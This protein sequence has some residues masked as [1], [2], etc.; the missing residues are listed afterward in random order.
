VPAAEPGRVPRVRA[1]TAADARAIGEVQ[2]L[3]WRV[4]YRGIVDDAFIDS[5]TIEAREASWRERLDDIGGMVILVLESADGAVVGF[6]SGGPCR[7]PDVAA[8]AEL[9]AIYILPEHQRDR[10]GR[11]LVRAFAREMSGRGC[12]TMLVQVLAENPARR[13]YES[14]GAR[15]LDDRPHQMGD[16]VYAEARYLWDDFATLLEA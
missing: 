9:Y 13:F 10:G 8:D 12:R 14:L 15:H 16:R 7:V 2:V 5:L 11:A 1:A 4:A 6:A 3:T